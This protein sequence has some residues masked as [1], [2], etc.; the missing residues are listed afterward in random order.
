MKFLS[1]FLLFLLSTLQ[2]IS[3]EHSIIPAPLS[4]IEK[5]GHFTLSTSTHYYQDTPLANQAV[6]Y[7]NHH[8][9]NVSN[10]TL[11]I[12][13]KTRA[14]VIF[15]YNKK[16]KEEAYTLSV[17]PKSIKVL[18]S[19]Q[20][21]FF[22]GVMTLMQ[23]MNPEIWSPIQLRTVD[24]TWTVD[25]CSV[26]D[27]PR[28]A[29]RGMML[30]SA[31]HFFSVPY[32]KKFIDR[33][34]QD[35]LNR[36]HWH[37]SDDEGWR[38][39]IKRYPLLTKVGATR[40][41]NSK[42]PYSLFPTL[43]GPKDKP[44][45]GY[46]TQTQIKD[47]VAYAKKRSVE[48]LPEI[49]LPAHAKAATVAYPHLLL[50]PKDSSDYRS[51]QKVHNNTIDAGLESSYQFIDGLIEE[52]TTLFPYPYIHMGGDE[53]PSGAWV[54]SPSVKLL[55]KTYNLQ[56][57]SEV[58]GYFFQ[59]VD[60]ILAKHN[61]TLIAWQEAKRNNSQLRKETVFIAWRGNKSVK[62][63]LKSTNNLLLAPATYFYYDQQYVKVK[64]ELGHTWAGPTDT[65]ELYSYQTQQLK[66]LASSK[67]A[68]YGLHSC[69]WSEHAHSEAIADYLVW[70]RALAFSELA[71]SPVDGL[72]WN[73]FEQ[74]IDASALRRLEMQ[75]VQYRKPTD[76]KKF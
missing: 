19:S 10:Y 20:A 69:L 66:G 22:Y 37:L 17:T 28:F 9:L 46:Y 34:A 26:D 4:Y 12:T 45:T 54:G 71:W 21:G 7:L 56:N 27:L 36:F 72:D 58:Q 23:L 60:A 6:E 73:N 3:L 70:P 50:N 76:Y 15:I 5:Q 8:L 65:K 44:Y 35:K 11:H 18:A 47:I 42:L 13:D 41:P 25:A 33:M 43:P 53:V 67:S 63:L 49:D 14:S 38:I 51:V 61:R 29:W 52:L 40:G 39:E 68:I 57:S 74:R 24:Q 48:I 64:G 16:L 32:V 55:M 1:L 2:A 62:R 31:R 30:D 59:R 75:N